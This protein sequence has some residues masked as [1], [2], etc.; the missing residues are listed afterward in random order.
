MSYLIA[1]ITRS[2]EPGSGNN[3]GEGIKT[4]I[5]HSCQDRVTAESE[6]CQPGLEQKK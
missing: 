6:F 5:F 4:E 3:A 2:P 1:L